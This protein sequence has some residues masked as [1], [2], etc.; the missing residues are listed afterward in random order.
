MLSVNLDRGS[1]NKDEY[2]Y[3]KISTSNCSF[4]GNESQTV[5]ESKN[6][7]KQSN[8]YKAPDSPSKLSKL[9]KKMS[10]SIIGQEILANFDNLKVNLSSL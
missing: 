2:K 7:S 9:S 4:A 3:S 1:S 10:S 5:D 6:N 8:K